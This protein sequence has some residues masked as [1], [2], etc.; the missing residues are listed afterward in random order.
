[1]ERLETRLLGGCGQQVLL[2]LSVDVGDR[3][4][5]GEGS[6]TVCHSHGRRNLDQ[7]PQFC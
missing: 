1:M 3:T 2:P 7:K 4:A 5:P 6:G